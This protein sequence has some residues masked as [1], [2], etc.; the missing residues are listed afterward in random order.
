[1]KALL[2]TFLISLAVTGVEAT[3]NE[4]KESLSIL[5]HSSLPAKFSLKVNNELIFDE[6]VAVPES[7]VIDREIYTIDMDFNLIPEADKLMVEIVDRGEDCSTETVFY[8]NERVDFEI[9][10]NKWTGKTVFARL[11]NFPL[12]P[13]VPTKPETPVV[14][15]V[16][17][18]I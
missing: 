15:E 10:V 14:S 8:I 11:N 9:Q 4:L 3:E 13:E 5:S 2:F 7:V 17:E 6:C 18:V 1:M 12:E 16:P